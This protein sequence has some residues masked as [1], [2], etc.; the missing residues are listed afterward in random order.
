MGSRHLLVLL[1]CTASSPVRRETHTQPTTVKQSTPLLNQGLAVRQ[2]ECLSVSKVITPRV[3]QNI[4]GEIAFILRTIDFIQHV[5]ISECSIMETSCTD[6]LCVN[7]CV[8][9]FL[10]H[11]LIVM[12]GNE[13]ETELFPFPSGCTSVQV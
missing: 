3:A 10:D 6:N 2:K 13:T 12:K 8:Q 11:E 1:A 5:K 9:K 4:H 7:R